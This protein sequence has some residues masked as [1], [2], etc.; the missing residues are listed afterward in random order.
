VLREI[1]ANFSSE[2]LPESLTALRTQLVD[3]LAA[4]A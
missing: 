4:A 2:L 3:R 1:D